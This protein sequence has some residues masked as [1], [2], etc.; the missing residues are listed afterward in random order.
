MKG[1]GEDGGRDRCL[2][3]AADDQRGDSADQADPDQSSTAV[4][5]EPLSQP[6]EPIGKP[7][8]IRAPDR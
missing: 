7:T 4:R 3:E 6:V 2:E 1:P 5:F 8:Q